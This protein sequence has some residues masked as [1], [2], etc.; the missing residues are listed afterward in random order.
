VEGF[1]RRGLTFEVGKGFWSTW[2][3]P[4][5]IV[6]A[7]VSRYVSKW[8][9][10]KRLEKILGFQKKSKLGQIGRMEQTYLPVLTQRPATPLDS[11]EEEEF[12]QNFRKI[13]G[14]IITL[15]EPLSRLSLDVNREII[16]FQ[17]RPLHSVLRVPTDFKTPIRTI[18]LSF[19][20]FL[21]SDKVQNQPF[22]VNGPTTH[23]MLL[24]RCLKLLSGPNGLRE[25][26]CDLAYPG[27]PRQ[28][29][30]PTVINKRL[31]TAYQYACRYWVHHVQYS[32][33]PIQ[34]DD[35]VHVFFQKHFLHWLEAL[36]LMNRIAEAIGH[37]GV[38]QS[39][40]SVSHY[41]ERTFQRACGS[42]VSY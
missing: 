1:D 35:Q 5:F 8:N 13:V 29:V 40:V 10:P 41:L 31:L 30:H 7:T 26:L 22:G 38:L 2:P 4:L 42:N 36:S 20:E 19:S 16:T 3:P 6:A 24:T 28:E 21:L 17:L 39:L 9:P 23:H 27:Q 33:V 25:N 32:M 14:S 12:Y 15:A 11:D 34:D 37:V 18:H